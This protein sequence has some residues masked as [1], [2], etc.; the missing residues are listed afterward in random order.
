MNS[1][2]SAMPATPLEA[3][4]TSAVVLQARLLR[5]ANLSQ[6]AIKARDLFKSAS[7]RRPLLRS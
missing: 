5:L 2:L 6:H 1:G 7:F 3:A 4:K